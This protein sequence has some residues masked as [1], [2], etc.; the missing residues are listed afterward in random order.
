[1]HSIVGLMSVSVG[2]VITEM[3]DNG[4]S[5]STALERTFRTGLFE[6][7]VFR[8]LEGTEAS[9]KLLMLARELGFSMELEDIEIEPLASRRDIDSWTNLGDAFAEEDRN[10]AARVTAAAE[11]GCTLRY[12][13][14]ID[15]TPAVVL[16][17]VP[18]VGGRASVRLEEV[19]LHS[20][21]AMVKGAVYYFAFHT[22]RYS[23]HPL[24]VQ[25]GS[26]FVWQCIANF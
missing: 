19:S 21:Y 11:K 10:M 6:D 16:G 12:V 17:G 3:C 20:P 23:Q 9:Q 2:T 22:E 4:T 13:Q 8:D 5:F 25:V 24:V 1:M 14:R 15:C 18:S 7:D 26:D